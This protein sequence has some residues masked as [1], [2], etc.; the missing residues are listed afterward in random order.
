MSI[1]A[2]QEPYSGEENWP[3][4]QWKTFI[5]TYVHIVTVSVR[6]CSSSGVFLCCTKI[7][8]I[9]PGC[10]CV[11]NTV[12]H[13]NME[14][15]KRTF[16]FLKKKKENKWKVWK[17]SWESVECYCQQYESC[18]HRSLWVI[19]VVLLM[20]RSGVASSL[21]GNSGAGSQV[22]KSLS[23]CKTF[24]LFTTKPCAEHTAIHWPN[25]CYQFL[26]LKVSIVILPN[27]G[28]VLKPGRI[29]FGLQDGSR[30]F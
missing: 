1:C 29:S 11:C 21:L 28:N 13:F 4:S 25:H 22:S 5:Y 26:C 30:T 24:T 12:F 23:F 16:F 2:K 8:S 6:V 10:K 18:D 14:Y 3:S 17:W 19:D 15:V 7:Q 9:I 20:C 27:K